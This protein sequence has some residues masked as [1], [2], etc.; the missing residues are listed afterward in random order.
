MVVKT[1][2]NTVLWRTPG[3]KKCVG[4]ERKKNERGEKKERKSE[5]ARERLY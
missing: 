1:L 3:R 2:R 4:G 5:R